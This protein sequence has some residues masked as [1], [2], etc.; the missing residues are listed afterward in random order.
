MYSPEEFEIMLHDVKYCRQL[1]FEGVVIGLLNA[2]GSIDT[3]RTAKLVDAAYPMEVTFHRAFDRCAN[4]F[5]ALEELIKVGCQR[6]LTSGQKP[7]APEGI[8]LIAQLN[9]AADNRI[10]IMPGSGVRKENIRMLAEKTGCTEFHSSLRSQSNS[11]MAFVHPSFAD[12]RDSY[13]N[14]A[15]E[16][17]EV[18]NLKMALE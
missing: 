17:A 4:P 14:N 2:D 10:I 6:I 5:Q 15:V 18:E 9:L 11:E 1:G 3:N 7:A 16:A 13:L 8:E 12:D